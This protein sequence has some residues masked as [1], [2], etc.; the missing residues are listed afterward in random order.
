MLLIT[1]RTMV[2]GAL[3]AALD[4]AFQGGCRWVMVREKD[5]TLQEHSNNIPLHQLV[6]ELLARML[7]MNQHLVFIRT[8]VD[9][10]L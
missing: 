5:M 7:T 8:L 1:D 3:T 2:R 6:F 9:L 4:R 10:A